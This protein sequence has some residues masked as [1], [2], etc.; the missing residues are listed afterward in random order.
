MTAGNAGIL[1]WV[2][3][4]AERGQFPLCKKKKVFGSINIKFKF[5]FAVVKF[6]T[7][8]M[9]HFLDFH[10][11]VAKGSRFQNKKLGQ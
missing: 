1:D 6:L 9:I 5:R 8:V 2:P 10:Y 7:R 4:K 3:P 11:S